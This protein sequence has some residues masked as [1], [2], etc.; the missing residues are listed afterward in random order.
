M[1]M[2]SETQTSDTTD[3]HNHRRLIDDFTRRA[4]GGLVDITRSEFKADPFP[5]YAALRADKP[6]CRIRMGRLEGYIVTRYD[7]VLSVLKDKQFSKDLRRVENAGEMSKRPWLPEFVRALE[8]NMLD[9]DDPNHARLRALVHRVFTPAR[10]EQL[11]DRIHVISNERLDAVQSSGR[12]ELI[13][14]FALPLPLT[15]I[16]EL[17][18]ISETDRNHFHKMS[19][20]IFLAPTVLNFI[21][22]IPSIWSLNRF[23]RRLLADRKTNPRDDLLTG[24][25]QAE[26]SGDKLTEDEQ[27]AMVILLLIAGHETT[28]N[29][30]A[31]GMLALLEHPDQLEWLRN[32]PDR[33]KPAV[34]ELLRYSSPVETATERY[35]TEDL[36]I[37]GTK[38]KRGELVL[39]V[40]ASANRDE[41]H[42]SRPNDLDLTREPNR[43]LA[44]GHGMHF[45][46]GAPLA[47]MEAQ[48]AINLLLKRLPNVRLAVAANE[49]RW[50]ATPVVRGLKALPLRFEDSG[51]STG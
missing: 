33:I 38:I 3:I 48:I 25:V 39:A 40:I 36:E 7:D 42:F 24:L 31:S 16:G 9:Q 13:R 11:R 23:L 43:H 14:D 5:F 2:K 19:Q 22:I 27:V 6:V 37:R 20:N 28:V 51:L 1:T 50:R 32:N 49:L 17:L 21:R 45:C 26:E 30:I 15:V 47:R 35:A 10:I 12:T 41:K 4:R 34:E 8:C 29:L 46:L 44:F 18:G